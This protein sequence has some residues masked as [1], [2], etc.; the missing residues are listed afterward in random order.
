MV[1]L[2]KNYVLMIASSLL[3]SGRMAVVDV[4]IDDP[5]AMKKDRLFFITGRSEQIEDAAVTTQGIMTLC[6]VHLDDVTVRH[7]RKIVPV[8]SDL[9][10]VDIYSPKVN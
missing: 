2:L 6:R 9:A 4:N 7:L 5:N 8:I 1:I 3:N 10:Q